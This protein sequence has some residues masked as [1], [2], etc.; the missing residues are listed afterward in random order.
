MISCSKDKD[1]VAVSDRAEALLGQWEYES[2]M[3]D[4]AV[5]IN[6]D[7]ISN[8]DLFNTQEIKQCKKDDLTFFNQDGPS[9][10]DEYLMTENALACEN[11]DPFSILEEDFYQLLDDNNT[12]SFEKR[13][14]MRIVE[15]TNKKLVVETDNV[16]N[17]QNIIITITYKRS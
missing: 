10:K 13:N 8:I 6:G 11:N 4:H 15:L 7:G 12:I 1:D 14:E 5:D 2:I 9:G 17:E 3:T 16:I